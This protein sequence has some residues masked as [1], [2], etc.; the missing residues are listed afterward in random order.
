VSFRVA[1]LRTPKDA[2]EASFLR[3]NRRIDPNYFRFRANYTGG[4]DNI[5]SITVYA[6]GSDDDT[7]P[8]A[9]ISGPQ[10]GLNN[11]FGVA[12]D[13]SGKIYVANFFDGTGSGSVT[14]YSP[15]SNGNAR[16]V[17]TIKGPNTELDNPSGIAI[18]AGGKIYVAN[19]GGER[20]NESS[21]TVYAPHS[22]GDVKPIARIAGPSTGLEDPCIAVDPNGKIYAGNTN[23][24]VTVYSPGS[25]GNVRPLA[26][27]VGP[28]QGDKTE[29]FHPDG[30][31]L[32]SSGNVYVANAYK[33]SRSDSGEEVRPQVTVYR[34]N[35]DGNVKPVALFAV[36]GGLGVAV[37][38]KGKIY[39]AN[40]EMV[41]VFSALGKEEGKAIRQIYTSARTGLHDVSGLAVD[42]KGN[43]F[44]AIV[45]DP[46]D[47]GKV[48]VFAAGHY[49]NVAPKFTIRGEESRLHWPEGIAI[50]PNEQLHVANRGD[51]R[52]TDSVGI[53][54]VRNNPEVQPSA[55][56]TGDKT[57]FRDDSRGTAV[58]SAG[59]SYVMEY[60]GDLLVYRAGSNGNVAP[61]AVING[62]YRGV[63]NPAGIAVDSSGRIYVT[64]G[65][66]VL[67]GVGAVV[68]YPAGSNGDAE[69]AAII[70]GPKTGIDD[71]R[72]IAVDSAGYIYVL[73]VS[74][75]DRRRY[76]SASP[77]VLVYPPNS[78]GD[79]APIVT[80]SGPLTGLDYPTSIAVGPPSALPPN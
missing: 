50:D 10:T 36:D 55:V 54:S 42:S 49:G 38:A 60:Q 53:Y 18:D 74:R 37:D 51:Q 76:A 31:A 29:L 35:S 75:P 64:G 46:D 9:T 69:P 3:S 47:S 7:D 33:W 16:P 79:V 25:D 52:V 57:R 32:D 80:I 15:G 26:T 2:P 12:V 66:S 48:A 21:I 45:E 65:K 71:P 63:Y 62:Y 22:S 5:G 59:N 70:T 20:T 23:D 19:R 1:L 72:G 4:A 44:V 39:V 73:N 67:R 40:V 17:A 77:S 6:A 30:I 78:N 41:A 24:S 27:I 11:P 8:T 43:I 34:A 68:I 28:D 13:S 56:I 58:D 61:M 14:M